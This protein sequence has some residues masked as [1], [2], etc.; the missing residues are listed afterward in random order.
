M[1]FVPRVVSVVVIV[2]PLGII[3]AAFVAVCLVSD[4]IWYYLGSLVLIE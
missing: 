3:T 4:D 1:P 2:F